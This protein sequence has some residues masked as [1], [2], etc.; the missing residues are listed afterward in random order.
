VNGVE[1]YNKRGIVQEIVSVD[2]LNLGGE[3]HLII[4]GSKRTQRFAF[5]TQQWQ[6]LTGT[7]D[8]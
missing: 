4:Y 7:E 3:I 2:T 6:H 8:N 1:R 5:S